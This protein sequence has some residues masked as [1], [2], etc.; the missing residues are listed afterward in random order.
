MMHAKGTCCVD[1]HTYELIVKG[2]PRVGS[3]EALLL[4]DSWQVAQSLIPPIVQLGQTG[5]GPTLKS[6]TSVVQ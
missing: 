6:H 3:P 5:P 2:E 1:Q 4:G